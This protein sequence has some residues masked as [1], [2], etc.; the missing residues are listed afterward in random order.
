MKYP[1][2]EISADKIAFNVQKLIKDANDRGIELVGVTKGVLAHPQIIDAYL[3]GGLNYLGDSR[4]QNVKRIR[5]YGFTGKVMLLRAPMLK[6]IS[7]VINYVDVSLVSEH[8]TLEALDLEANRLGKKHSFVV[9]VDVGD[10]REGV[11]PEDVD[12]F[13]VDSQKYENLQFLGLGLNVGCFGGV[14]PTWDNAQVL[15]ELKSKLESRGIEVPTLS[16]GSTCGISIMYKEQLPAQINQLRVGEA[17]LIGND[18]VREV[19][20]PG[21]YQ[22]TFRLTAEI[23]EIKE[24]PSQP[25]GEIG[26]D[27]FGNTPHFPDRGIRKRAIAAV[28]KQDV[29]INSLI[30]EDKHVTIEG[31]SSDHLI[32][33]ISDSQREYSIGDEISFDMEYGTV[34]FSMNSPYVSK[35][36]YWNTI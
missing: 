21:T 34:L 18:S 36:F 24:R 7:Q 28:G 5:D 4:I 16:G 2:V 6:E 15:V 11:M 22:N 9:M 19:K 17:F 25:A 35:E 26:K 1:K 8:K 33:D 12:E 32:L 3:E 29:V 31:A 27:P 10:R 23:L 30:P 14:L 13:V 20:I